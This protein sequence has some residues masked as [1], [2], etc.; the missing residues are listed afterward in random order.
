MAVE[1]GTGLWRK[2]GKGL[3]HNPPISFNQPWGP[4]S[5]SESGPGPPPHDSGIRG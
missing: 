4:G 2:E 3:S 5:A 1:T